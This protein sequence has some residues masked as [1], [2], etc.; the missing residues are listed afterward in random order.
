MSTGCS[1]PGPSPGGPPLQAGRQPNPELSAGF[2]ERDGELQVQMEIAKGQ[3][4]CDAS[5][6]HPKELLLPAN[7]AVPK[8]TSAPS[9]I[10]QKGRDQRKASGK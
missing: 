2:L 9:G 8:G 1:F 5:G 3:E 4:S 10:R 6:G 7:G